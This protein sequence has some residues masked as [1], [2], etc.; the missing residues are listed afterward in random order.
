MPEHIGTNF[1]TKSVSLC[2]SLTLV[3]AACSCFK[4]H[5]QTFENGGNDGWFFAGTL[6]RQDRIDLTA[7]L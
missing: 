4:K 3:I 1:T 2:G 5:A 7:H 6:D